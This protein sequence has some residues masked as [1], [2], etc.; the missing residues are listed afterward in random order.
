MCI[1]C[2]RGF[3]RFNA[4]WVPS[5]DAPLVQLARG[6][7]NVLSAMLPCLLLL[8]LNGERAVAASLRRSRFLVSLV[9]LPGLWHRRNCLVEKQSAV[10]SL[11]FTRLWNA[12]NGRQG[13]QIMP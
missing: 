8:L 1:Q 2:G 13:K 4:H 12:C 9:L 10:D 5:V 6:L 3:D 7:A 11:V